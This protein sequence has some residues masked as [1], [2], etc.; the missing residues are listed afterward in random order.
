MD[1]QRSVN[2]FKKKDLHNMTGGKLRNLLSKHYTDLGFKIPKFIK[3]GDFTH[4]NVE[5]AKNRIVNKSEKIIKNNV[6]KNLKG[7]NNLNNNQLDKE[8][9]KRVDKLN[10]KKENVISRINNLNLFSSK[11]MNYIT[12]EGV[13]LN[14]NSRM[15]FI[16][17]VDLKKTGKQIQEKKEDKLLRIAELDKQLKQTTPLQIIKKIF[18][19]KKEDKFFENTL[20]A[21]EEHGMNKADINALSSTF[22][23]LNPVKKSLTVKGV[24]DKIREKYEEML[25]NTDLTSS[26]KDE[27]LR[28]Y[29]NAVNGV[30]LEAERYE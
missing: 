27:V 5:R 30:L 3:E 13:A 25:Q 10:K 1:K 8:I 19:T 18:N 24:L 4:D 12:G 7:L 20:N 17:G 28:K 11:D 2:A 9:E 21:M 14:T 26:D 23:N 15:L 29:F 16:D 6:I 22:N